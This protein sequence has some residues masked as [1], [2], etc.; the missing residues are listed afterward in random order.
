M[1]V[2]FVLAILFEILLAEV[3]PTQSSLKFVIKVSYTTFLNYTITFYIYLVIYMRSLMEIV[4]PHGSLF[5]QPNLVCQQEVDW[6]NR[7]GTLFSE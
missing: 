6:K 7:N 2:I 3:R 1:R 4:L 5:D